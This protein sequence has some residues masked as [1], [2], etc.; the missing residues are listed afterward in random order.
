MSVYGAAG[1]AYRDTTK[2]MTATLPLAT[3]VAAGVTIGPPLVRSIQTAPSAG[4]WLAG[5]WLVLVCLLLLVAGVGLVLRAGA[6]VLSTGPN[7]PADLIKQGSGDAEAAIREGVAL[8]YYAD[9]PSFVRDLT[10]WIAA[11][12]ATDVNDEGARAKVTANAAVEAS[13]S[14]KRGRWC[15]LSRDAV[16]SKPTDGPDPRQERLIGALAAIGE[17]SA[18]HKI[19]HAFRDFRRS[20][21]G[22]VLAIVVALALAPVQLP[23]GPA[24]TA[25][26]PVTVEVSDAGA[27]DLWSVTE[28]TDPMLSTY[29]AIGGTWD[30]PLLAVDGPGC[31]FGATWAPASSDAEVRPV[32][33]AT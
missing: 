2:W 29:I 19:Q 1:D 23:S 25:P 22:G 12:D 26:I 32:A 33:P 7:L 20:F 15:S 13:A 18:L 17:W 31:R 28:C 16:G 11:M 9:G 14:A 24:V 3:F 5:H 4:A 10:G 8:P 30:A 27:A 21:A 6:R